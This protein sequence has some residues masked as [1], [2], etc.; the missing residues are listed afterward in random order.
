[1]HVN[2]TD[3]FSQNIM[4]TVL[5]LYLNKL[6]WLR[7]SEKSIIAKSNIHLVV[8]PLMP[9]KICRKLRSMFLLS[10][11]FVSLKIIHLNIIVCIWAKVFQFHMARSSSGLRPKTSSLPCTYSNHWALPPND[12][13][14]LMNCRIS[15]EHGVKVIARLIAVADFEFHSYITFCVSST[16][17]LVLS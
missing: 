8:C 13:I 5:I 1:M 3:T 14:C 7:W 16:S 4:T 11:Y 10:V 9:I 17:T 6:V 15:H 2:C 12:E